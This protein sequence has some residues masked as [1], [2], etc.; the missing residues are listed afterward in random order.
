MIL[1]CLQ[2]PRLARTNLINSMDGLEKEIQACADRAKQ[3]EEQFDVL[4]HC[5]D[6]VNLAMADEAGKT[7]VYHVV[8]RRSRLGLTR[9]QN[10]PRCKRIE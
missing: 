6:E 9:P 5:A 7:Q 1:M 8:R 10:V 3:I 4:V 2:D